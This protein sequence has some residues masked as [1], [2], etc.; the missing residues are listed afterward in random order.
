MDRSSEPVR[1]LASI[2]MA[3]VHTHDLESG[4]NGK[5]KSSVRPIDGEE[6]IIEAVDDKEKVKPAPIKE[7]FRFASTADM[8]VMGVGVFGTLLAGASLPGRCTIIAAPVPSLV[9]VC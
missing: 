1:I 2:V 5:T 3:E 7:I 9:S 4:K 8:T 6:V